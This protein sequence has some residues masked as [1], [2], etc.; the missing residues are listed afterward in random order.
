MSATY[1]VATITVALRHMDSRGEP[2]SAFVKG[3]ELAKMLVSSCYESCDIVIFI[4]SVVGVINCA[5]LVKNLR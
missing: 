5:E 1:V 2:V 3:G 4:T